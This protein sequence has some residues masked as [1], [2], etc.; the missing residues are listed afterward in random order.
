MNISNKTI[1]T[2]V[3]FALVPLILAALFAYQTEKR[4]IHDDT[5]NH[6]TEVVNRRAAAFQMSATSTEATAL[7]L[8]EDYGYL[9]DTGELMVFSES[10]T[11]ATVTMALMTPVRFAEDANTDDLNAMT[12]R[13]AESLSSASNSSFASSPAP[14]SRLDIIDYR[15]KEVF[16]VI[17]MIPDIH[18][19]LVA[20]QDLAEA[21]ASLLFIQGSFLLFTFMIAL[22]AIF[23]GLLAARELADPLRL[24]AVAVADFAAHPERQ[25][26]APEIT[27]AGG[28]EIWI[29]RNEFTKMSQKMGHYHQELEDEVKKRTEEL[30]AFSYSVSHDLRA[31]LR[32]MDGFVNVLTEEYG[33]SFD[34]EGKR[35]IGII[36]SNAKQMGRLID[37]LL[38]FSRLGRQEVKKARVAMTPLVRSVLNDLL[39]HPASKSNAVADIRIGDLPDAFADQELIRLVWVNLLSNAIK[40]SGNKKKPNIEIGGKVEGN[41]AAYFV[42]DNGVGFDM[43]Y[44]DKLFKVFQ[45]LHPMKEF[46]GTGVGL[47]NVKRIVERHGGEV[48]A[49]GE[50]GKGATFSFTLP[51]YL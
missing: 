39:Q 23:F 31:P 38:S 51:S 49:E 3:A 29:L 35:V 47:A 32:A 40:F 28:D 33:G 8:T 15:G 27:R 26:C 41:T 36:Q 37:D 45:R 34:D 10:A 16:A 5:Y 18:I 20:K 24:L 22:L 1:L 42:K 4:R 7:R 14:P 44:A 9:G 46:E 2:L 17:K 43:R 13:I 19:V 30:E 6:L 50:V 12:A 21:E 48:R 25:M 11:N